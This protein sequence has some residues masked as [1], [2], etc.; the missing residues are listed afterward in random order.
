MNSKDF[1]QELASRIESGTKDTEKMISDL[2]SVIAS[3]ISEEKSV[4]VQGFGQFFVKKLNERVEVNPDTNVRMLMPPQLSVVYKQSPLL[5]KKERK[6]ASA[7]E[8]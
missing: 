6:E 2:A 4:T 7:D 1:I 8:N 3:N 5:L